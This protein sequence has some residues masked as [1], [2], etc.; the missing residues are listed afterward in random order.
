MNVLAF[1][2]VIIAYISICYLGAKLY[3][4]LVANAYQKSWSNIIKKCVVAILFLGFAIVEIPIAIFFPAWANAK[5]EVMGNER[6]STSALIMFGCFVL[7]VTLWMACRSKAGR[8]FA[9]VTGGQE[10]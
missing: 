8:R 5:L 10:R 6:A 3:F 1:V 4:L 7:L 2:A 9:K